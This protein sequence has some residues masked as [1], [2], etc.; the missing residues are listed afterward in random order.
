M[1][2]NPSDPTIEEAIRQLEVT[3]LNVAYAG[4]VLIDVNSPISPAPRPAMPTSALWTARVKAL[5]PRQAASP[6][7]LWPPLCVFVQDA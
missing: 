3:A 2:P 5:Q 6:I 1:R 7:P 4:F